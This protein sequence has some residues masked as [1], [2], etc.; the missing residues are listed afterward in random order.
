[1][2]RKINKSLKECRFNEFA[3]LYQKQKNN[4]N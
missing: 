3:T 1:M 2:K 4:M